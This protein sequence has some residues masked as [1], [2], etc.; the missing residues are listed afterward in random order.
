MPVGS[1]V[2]TLSDMNNPGDNALKWSNEVHDLGDNFRGKPNLTVS[3]KHH[4][5]CLTRRMAT[6]K[7]LPSFQ[8]CCSITRTLPVIREFTIRKATK[9]EIRPWPVIQDQLAII[10]KILQILHYYYL[11]TASLT[12]LVTTPF[13]A[14]ASVNP[15]TQYTI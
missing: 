14:R 12:K 4:T 13:S 7:T 8:N 6:G 1:N 9:E 11:P 2:W 5:I 15:T 10:F 3:H